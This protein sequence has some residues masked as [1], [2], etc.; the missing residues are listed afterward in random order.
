M[1]AIAVIPRGRHGRRGN[2]FQQRQFRQGR[3]AEPR[4]NST[5]LMLSRNASSLTNDQLQTAAQNYFN[6]LFNRPEAQATSKSPP[7]IRRPAVRV[8]PSPAPPMVPTTFLGVLGYNEIPVS[9]SSTAKWGSS[10]LR[11]ALGARQHRFDGCRRQ[12]WRAQ[13]RDQELADAIAGRRQRRRRRLCL[14]RSLR[15][16]REN[17]HLRL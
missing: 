9:D 3:D 14:D 5:A 15:Q 11:V 6:A 2:R 7:L 8:Y 17:R 16:R 1:F 4:S 12:A 10:R 13:D